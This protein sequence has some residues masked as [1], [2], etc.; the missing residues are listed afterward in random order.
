M[1]E[2]K[3]KSDEEINKLWANAIKLGEKIDELEE[4]LNK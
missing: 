2:K 3:N 4:K 1:F